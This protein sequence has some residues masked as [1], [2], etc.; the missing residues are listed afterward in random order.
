MNK[1][2]D[3][4]F[5]LVI[6]GDQGVGKSCINQRLADKEFT[7]SYIPT[8]GVEFTQKKLLIENK[9]VSLQIWDTSGQQRFM[10]IAISYLKSADAILIVYDITDDSSFSDIKGWLNLLERQG[11]RDL[12][13]IVIGNKSDLE[14]KR[15]VDTEQ[16]RQ[17]CR[18]NNLL[19]HEISVKN[20]KDQ[21]N[22]EIL[23]LSLQLITKKDK[24][25]EKERLKSISQQQ[26]LQNET[27]EQKDD[28]VHNQELAS[29][30]E[31]VKELKEQMKNI[32]DEFQSEIKNLKQRVNE[33]E[34]ELLRK[35]L[36]LILK[37]S[38]MMQLI[39]LSHL[40]LILISCLPQNN[41]HIR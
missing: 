31:D 20:S 41:L 22:Q 1:E 29:L 39:S 33:L 15:K 35:I 36:L 3:Y 16:A 27:N 10:M 23:E 25:M 4:K 24:L 34:N 9:N 38:L 18:E 21:L 26:D 32:T 6:I 19:F 28:S 14:Q 13:I 37:K 7:D 40:I 2:Q 30:K 12:P 5:K 17:Y 8:I 11:I